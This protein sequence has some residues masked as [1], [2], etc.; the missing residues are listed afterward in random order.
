MRKTILAV[1]TLALLLTSCAKEKDTE[2]APVFTGGSSTV[3]WVSKAATVE[4]L[5][6]EA[7]LS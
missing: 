6:S 1:L 3:E 5:V 4:E 2:V 7:T